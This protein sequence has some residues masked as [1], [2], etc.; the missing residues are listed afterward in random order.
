MYPNYSNT[1]FQVFFISFQC[2]ECVF[3]V[4]EI[5]D[6]PIYLN[7]YHLFWNITTCDK[8]NGTLMRHISLCIKTVVTAGKKQFLNPTESI[9]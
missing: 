4:T 6:K 1:R 5:R 8:Q 3:S 2:F 7:V 9:Q